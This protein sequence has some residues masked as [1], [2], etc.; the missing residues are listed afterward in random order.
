MLVPCASFWWITTKAP[1]STTT[2]G[3]VQISD[4]RDQREGPGTA[5][6]RSSSP[7]SPGSVMRLRVPEKPLVE[8]SCR[9]QGQDHDC[10]EGPGAPTDADQREGLDLHQRGEQRDGVNIE[11]RPFADEFY[12]PE[13]ATAVPTVAR[14]SRPSGM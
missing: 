12:H 6:G 4:K 2:T 10:A 14:R 9:E 7:C 11:H 13:Q 8:S 1:A 5:A 3:R